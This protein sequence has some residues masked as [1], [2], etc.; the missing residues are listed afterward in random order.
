MI[1]A[2][3]QRFTSCDTV[4][5]DRTGRGDAGGAARR[6]DGAG[7]RAI[8]S[9]MAGAVGYAGGR[10]LL[11]PVEPNRTILSPILPSIYKYGEC[12][13]TIHFIPSSFHVMCVS[14][15]GSLLPVR[16]PI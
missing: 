14:C 2:E 13:G 15:P 7:C 11:C 16:E 4:R 3:T 1:A 10:A 5:R 8:G 6:S 12:N 9:A